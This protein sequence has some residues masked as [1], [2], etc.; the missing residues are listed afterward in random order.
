MEATLAIW[1]DHPF[2]ARFIK[3]VTNKIDT[4]SKIAGILAGLEGDGWT[5]QYESTEEHEVCWIATREFPDS[6]EF[7]TVTQACEK[8]NGEHWGSL[9]VESV[10]LW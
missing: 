7:K 8:H 5:V 6:A 1:C 4:A 3:D 10:S 2:N 9:Y